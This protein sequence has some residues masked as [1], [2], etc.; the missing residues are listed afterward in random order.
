MLDYHWLFNSKLSKDSFF[1]PLGAGIAM[2]IPLICSLFLHDS[3][4]ASIGVMGSFSYLAFQYSSISYNVRA[5]SLHGLALLLALSLGLYSALAPWSIPF[6]ISAISFLAFILTKLYHIPKPDYFFVIMLY[7]TGTNL[8]ATHGVLVT[9]SYLFYGIAGALIS[10]L[11]VSLVEKLPITIPKEVYARLRIHDKYYTTI[12]KEPM[13]ILKAMHFSMI[14]FCSAY[15]SQLLMHHNGYWILISSA[16]VLSGEHMDKI[17]ERS[18]QRVI[19]GVIGLLLG[20]MI[21][22]LDLPLTINFTVLIML[23]IATEYF[24]PRNYAVANFFINPQV[25]LLGTLVAGN[26]S[27]NL[28]PYRFSGILIG[29]TI[30]VILMLIA[31]YAVNTLNK[32]Y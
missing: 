24:M 19:G 21:I 5:I 28:V 22:S 3:K 1:R 18:I 13:T 20:S 31:D 8:P 16:A 25:L 12:Y 15:I 27:F 6:T 17:K 2:A 23:N 29:S 4:I 10:G 7:A 11:F 26:V 32:K 30:A 14:L 9:S